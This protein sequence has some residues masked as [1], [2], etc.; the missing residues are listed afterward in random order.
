MNEFAIVVIGYNRPISLGRILKSLGEA[1][2]PSCIDLIISID[3]QGTKDVNRIAEDFVWDSGKKIV[4]IH[5]EKKGLIAHFLWAGEQTRDYEHVIFF[6]DDLYLS[7]T[8]IIFSIDAA[9]F[10]KNEDKVAGIS[11]YNPGICELNATL[12]NKI[13]DGFDV[14]F[15]QHPYWGN[16][17]TK[18]KWDDFIKWKESYQLDESILPSMIA[19]WKTGSFKRIFIQYLI[20]TKK[21]IV[22]PRTS[23][24]T[25]FSDAG[26]HSVTQQY[27]YQTPIQLNYHG[28]RFCKI[29]ES[30]AIYD[31]FMEIDQSI[32]KHY[33]TAL[34]EI[35]FEVDLKQNRTRYSKN[36]VLTTKPVN[37]Y[38]LSFSNHMKPLEQNVLLSISGDGIYLA[39]SEDIK[40]VI[41]NSVLFRDI[42]SN[43][44]ITRRN[45]FM[46]YLWALKNAIRRHIIQTK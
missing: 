2:I 33:C 34:K 29:D 12:F 26:L 31:A 28:Y 42:E 14:F 27:Q 16:I 45:I 19:A 6:E 3:N 10:Y 40:K 43:Y 15:L 17:W 38:I 44:T 1:E 20:E 41:N 37:N 22:I 11:L 18:K 35:D 36:Y 30:E 13:H 25:N 32:L 4:V 23:F 21:Y 7:K 9:R 8:A 24:C 46:Y 39:A 5:K